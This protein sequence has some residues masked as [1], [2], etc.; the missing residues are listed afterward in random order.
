MGVGVF[1]KDPLGLSRRPTMAGEEV[2]VWAVATIGAPPL[3]HRTA[4]G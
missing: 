4:A 2:I 3:S 1:D